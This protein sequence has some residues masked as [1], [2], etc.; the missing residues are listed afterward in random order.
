MPA[1]SQAQAVKAPGRS[2]EHRI[3]APGIARYAEGTSCLKLRRSKSTPASDFIA[4]SCSLW[5]FDTNSGSGPREAAHHFLS[6]LTS[7]SP[8]YFALKKLLK[9]D[10][11]VV[12]GIM[13]TVHKRYPA[14]TGPL[15]DEFPGT[16]MSLQLTKVTL[17]EGAP[18]CRI[19]LKPL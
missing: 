14:S 4:S 10:G 5:S 2:R 6:S 18:F 16:R 8:V 3:P 7:Y 1:S 9:R 15:Q 17:P 13:G 12:L 19:V 11:I